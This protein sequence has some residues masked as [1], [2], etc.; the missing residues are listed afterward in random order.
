[1]T[2][3]YLSGYVER[4]PAIPERLWCNE[5]RRWIEGRTVA[6]VERLAREHAAEQREPEKHEVTAW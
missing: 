1:M 4:R 6:D 3:P 2:V 5:C